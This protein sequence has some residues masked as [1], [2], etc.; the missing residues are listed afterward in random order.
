MKI[1]LQSQVISRL[2]FEYKRLLKRGL[3][4]IFSKLGFEIYI[5]STDEIIISRKLQETLTLIKIGNT[6]VQ[7]DLITDKRFKDYLASNTRYFC[8]GIQV[9]KVLYLLDSKRNGFFVEFGACDGVL[10]SNTL[11][12]EN[13][14]SWTGIL[15]EPS[16]G[17]ARSI[18]ANRKASIDTRA[19]WSKTGEFL[20]FAEVSANGLSGIF[21]SIRSFEGVKKRESLGVKKYL[22]ETI[23]LNDLLKLY[24][25]PK[26]FDFL[27]IDTEGSE[28]EIIESFDLQKYR[29][30]VVTIEFV[31]TKHVA[32]KLIS[33]FSQEG[34]KLVS[35]GLNDLN[36]LWFK[37]D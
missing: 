8:E 15:A 33:R 7:T 16:K 23:S 19:V 35:F 25:A 30:K 4:V 17:Y 2:K 10:H 13:K 14:F 36:N 6:T 34:Y 24:D 29:P 28:L 27:S 22:V 31:G 1:I 11:L 32:D 26:S 18:K 9:L 37:L 3:K 12:L 20:E 21:S 5:N